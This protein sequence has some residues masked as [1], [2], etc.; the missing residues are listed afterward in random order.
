MPAAPE[1]AK[2]VPRLGGKGSNPDFGEIEDGLASRSEI[3]SLIEGLPGRL[4]QYLESVETEI[5]RSKRNIVTVARHE[6]EIGSEEA[7]A[8]YIQAEADL[9]AKHRAAL[10]MRQTMYQMLLDM[11]AAM[12]QV[13]GERTLLG[14]LNAKPSATVRDKALESLSAKAL[15]RHSGDGG[16]ASPPKADQR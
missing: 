7:L 3:S 15:A 11:D 12:G 1:L 10:D 13:I 9:A 4:R 16:P 2:P 14:V 5:E 8:H 6:E